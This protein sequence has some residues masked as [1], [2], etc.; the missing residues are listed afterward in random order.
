VGAA[1]DGD[2]GD[3]GADVVVTAV[4]G[5]ADSGAVEDMGTETDTAVLRSAKAHSMVA[6]DQAHLSC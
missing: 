1:V 2:G 4:T 6:P 5:M 3:A